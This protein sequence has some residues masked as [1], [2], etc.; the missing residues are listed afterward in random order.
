MK[1]QT[2]KCKNCKRIATDWKNNPK[3]SCP[4]CEIICEEC[5]NEECNCD[6]F[7]KQK[8]EDEEYRDLLDY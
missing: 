6:I 7:K 3:T 8:Q 4:K 1:T 2:Y 5:G